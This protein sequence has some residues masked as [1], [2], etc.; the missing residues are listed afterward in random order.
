MSV[1]PTKTVIFTDTCCPRHD[2][3][4]KVQDTKSNCGKLGKMKVINKVL[5]IVKMNIIELFAINPVKKW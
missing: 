1:N 3:I 4:F 5:R 2:N